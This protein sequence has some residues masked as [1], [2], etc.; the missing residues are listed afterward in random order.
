MDEIKRIKNI[1][2][3]EIK[4]MAKF[5]ND[6]YLTDCIGN[7]ENCF[8]KVFYDNRILFCEFPA[9]CARLLINK[10]N[11]LLNELVDEICEERREEAIYWNFVKRDQE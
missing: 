5:V 2:I 8:C 1:N 11:G 7:K 6:N 3:D 9:Y 4:R 10:E